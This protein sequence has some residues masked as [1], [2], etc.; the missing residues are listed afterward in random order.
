MQALTKLHWQQFSECTCT[1]QA[2]RLNTDLLLLNFM[3]ENEYLPA[4]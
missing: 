4:S 2:V 1:S 3:A